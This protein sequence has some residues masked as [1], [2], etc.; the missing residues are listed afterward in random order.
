[1]V[2]GGSLRKWIAAAALLALVVPSPACAQNR[3]SI[4]GLTD[5]AFGTIVSPIDQSNSQNVSIC[6]YQN[7]FWGYIFPNPYSVVATG[8][9]SGGAFTLASGAATL[10]YDVRW[11]DTANQTTGI[12]LQPGLAASGF[13]NAATH[14]TCDSNPDNASLIV[15]IRAAQLATAAAGTYSGTL[16]IMISPN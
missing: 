9:G 6:S 14:Y 7:G 15:T 11:S 12:Q 16:Q 1:M 2:Y 5:V 4:T 8:S 3:A 13:G 10:A